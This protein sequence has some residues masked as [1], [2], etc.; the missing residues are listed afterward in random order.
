MANNADHPIEIFPVWVCGVGR[1][2]YH[3]GSNCDPN[4]PHGPEWRCGWVYELSYRA[5]PSS[6]SLLESYGIVVHD[7]PNMGR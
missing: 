7:A 1:S 5:T 6:K 4:E 2:G 3:N